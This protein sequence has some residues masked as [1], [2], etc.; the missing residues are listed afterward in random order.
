M[1]KRLPELLQIYSTPLESLS[2]TDNQSLDNV[3]HIT[4]KILEERL[5]VGILSI[6]EL[7]D[8][9]QV[10][11]ISVEKDKEISD[12]LIIL[13]YLKNSYWTS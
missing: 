7:V 12:A 9:N 6:H 2:H 8:N 5:I 11:V 3:V 4:K 10:R 1:N 13:A